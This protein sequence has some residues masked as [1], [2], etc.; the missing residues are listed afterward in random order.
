M[1]SV[2]VPEI[3]AAIDENGL[4]FFCILLFVL[5]LNSHFCYERRC[6]KQDR[7]YLTVKVNDNALF[8]AQPYAYA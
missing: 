6:E 8:R 7:F 5:L 1:I 3:C 4:C 2:D